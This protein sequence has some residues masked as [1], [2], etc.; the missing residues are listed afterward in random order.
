MPRNDHDALDA[1]LLS[2]RFDHPNLARIVDAG[3]DGDVPWVARE[4]IPDPWD[5]DACWLDQRDRVQAL[6]SVLGVLDGVGMPHGRVGRGNLRLRDGVAVLVDP[7]GQGTA[8]DDLRGLGQA[9]GAPAPDAPEGMAGWLADLSAGRWDRAIDAATALKAID[10]RER[11][12]RSTRPAIGTALLALRP[13]PLRGRRAERQALSDVVEQGRTACAVAMVAGAP[14][15]GSTRLVHAVAAKAHRSGAATAFRARRLVDLVPTDAEHAELRSLLES[16]HGP[17]AARYAQLRRSLVARAG[18]RLPLVVLD[19]AHLHLDHLAFAHAW[20]A[21][22][23]PGAL[24][25]DLDAEAMATDPMLQ[26]AL[27]ALQEAGATLV[28]LG[29]VPEEELASAL[30]YLVPDA[31][32]LAHTAATLAE[33]SPLAAHLAMLSLARVG[34]VPLDHSPWTTWLDLVL[35]TAAD[36]HLLEVAAALED[37]LD[38]AEWTAAGSRL[39][40]QWSRDLPRRLRLHGIGKRSRGRWRLAHASLRQVLRESSQRE[41]RWEAVNRACAAVVRGPRSAMRRGAHLLEAGDRDEAAAA[42][43]LALEDAD[44]DVV[45]QVV[46]LLERTLADVPPDDPRRVA[47]ALARLRISQGEKAIEVG[48]QVARHG[49]TEDRFQVAVHMVGQLA[50]LSR[51][52]QDTWVARTFALARKLGSPHATSLAWQAQARVRLARGDVQ[53]AERA[54]AKAASMSPSPAAQVF[55]AELLTALGRSDEAEPLLAAID[56]DDAVAVRL[57][58]AWGH[59]AFAEGHYERA[60]LFYFAAE[61]LADLAGEPD[62]EVTWHVGKT[63]MMLG[64]VDEAA[65][66]FSLLEHGQGGAAVVGHVGALAV[67]SQ[68]GEAGALSLALEWLVDHAE[69]IVDPGVPRLLEQAASVAEAGVAT[70]I[71]AVIGRCTVVA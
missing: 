26:R 22:R 25:V 49:T 51:D 70:Q 52:E 69:P 14:G 66:R 11:P 2:L 6:L 5:A 12:Q 45:E 13:P 28:E 34:E 36:Q 53:G 8:R 41:G 59:R 3:T 30:A 47:S 40:L 67:A 15:M 29:P 4:D 43:L 71:R 27:Q 60:L 50:H 46:N 38:P 35:P 33:G 44:P 31:P 48:R 58:A 17:S 68:R 7:L 55:R 21:G 19:D 16:A 39:G 63:L 32:E 10:A 62:L 1:A 64:R 54:L 56:P 57:Q 20:L 37:P 9:L 24:F 61:A 18:E 23:A 42:L 65:E